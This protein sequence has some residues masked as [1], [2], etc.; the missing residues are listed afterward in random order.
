MAHAHSD[1]QHGQR[2]GQLVAANEIV[3]WDNIVSLA[4]ENLDTM[5]I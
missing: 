2:D 5:A 3:R 4:F 1:D